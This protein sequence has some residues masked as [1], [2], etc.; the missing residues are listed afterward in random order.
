MSRSRL[1]DLLP[2][3]RAW[4]PVRWESRLLHRFFPLRRARGATDTRCYVGRC[5]RR[6]SLVYYAKMVNAG[7]NRRMGRRCVPSF[8]FPWYRLRVFDHPFQLQ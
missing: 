8:L 7:I 2:L 6:F 4:C 5:Q 1:D 3:P